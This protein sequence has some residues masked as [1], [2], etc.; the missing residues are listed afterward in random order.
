MNPNAPLGVLVCG[1]GGF[2]YG[3]L[4]KLV[5]FE[6]EIN[7]SC[8]LRGALSLGSCVRTLAHQPVLMNGEQTVAQE[9]NLKCLLPGRCALLAK[10]WWT[11]M[12]QLWWFD[13]TC[14]ETVYCVAHVANKFSQRIQ[15]LKSHKN[16]S[17]LKT[18]QNHSHRHWHQHWHSHRHSHRHWH[19]HWHSHRHRQLKILFGTV[20]VVA[21]EYGRSLVRFSETL[22]Q[23]RGGGV[24][25]A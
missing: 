25:C 24:A 22:S 20:N 18:Q 11:M 1:E 23:K 6:E 10:L 12:L 16:H 7:W 15:K 2:S 19:Q 3:G 8:L 4:Q 13:E 5:L 9:C 21:L 14:G 17:C